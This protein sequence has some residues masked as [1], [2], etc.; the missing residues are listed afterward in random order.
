MVGQGDEAGTNPMESSQLI[1]L[2]FLIDHLGYLR[3]SR[4][5]LTAERS[6]LLRPSTATALC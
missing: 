5:L 1:D 4:S 2:S 3:P 6:A